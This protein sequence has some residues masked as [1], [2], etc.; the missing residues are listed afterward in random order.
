MKKLAGFLA[1]FGIFIFA[2]IFFQMP[3]HTKGEEGYALLRI[4]IRADSNDKADQAVKLL[5]RDAVT[6]ILSSSLRNATSL[7]EAK[8]IVSDKQT[9]VRKKANE[10]LRKNGFLYDSRVRLTYEYF[11]TRSYQGIVVE[12]GYYDALIIELGSGQ[13]DN[14][15]CVLYPSLCYGTSEEGTAVYKS[16]IAQI[17]RKYFG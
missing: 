14:W 17:W 6:Q 5:V 2:L 4:H 7:Q 12:S 16:R 10:V 8:S 15:W 9:T 13:G 11:P 3:T 1:I